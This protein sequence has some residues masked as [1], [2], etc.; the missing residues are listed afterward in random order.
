MSVRANADDKQY[1]VVTV[2]R[3]PN[4]YDAESEWGQYNSRAAARG[5]ATWIVNDELDDRRR[6]GF[7][8]YK[9]VLIQENVNGVWKTIDTR[10]IDG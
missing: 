4:R 3:D 2:F 6:N 8:L 9:A 1:R 10:N 5:Q 7:S